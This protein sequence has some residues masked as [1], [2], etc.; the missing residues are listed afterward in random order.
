VGQSITPSGSF[1]Q[2]AVGEYFTCAL[3][4]DQ[5]VTCWGLDLPN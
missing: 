4:S 5:I 1:L 3:R 2:V